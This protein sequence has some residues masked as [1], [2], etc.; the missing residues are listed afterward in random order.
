MTTADEALFNLQNFFQQ[1]GNPEI[2]I[3]FSFLITGVVLAK[4]GAWS[5]ECPSGMAVC[6]LRTRI[7]PDQ[8]TTTI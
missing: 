2:S 4:W 8:G 5:G 1:F 7:Q 6:S 3:L